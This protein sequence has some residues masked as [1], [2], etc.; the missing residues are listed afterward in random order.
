MITCM[1]DFA[2][3]L[4]LFLKGYLS[5]GCIN[6]WLRDSNIFFIYMQAHT[7]HFKIGS[8]WGDG[9]AIYLKY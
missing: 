9:K 8:G 6:F 4:A 1:I 2:S 5:Q 3:F 7:K